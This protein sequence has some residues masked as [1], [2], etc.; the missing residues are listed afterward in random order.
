MENTKYEKRIGVKALWKTI[1][2][3]WRILLVI[4]VPIAMISIITTQLIL[5]KKYS[6]NFTLNNNYVN[7]DN[8]NYEKVVA[9]VKKEETLAQT[10]QNLANRNIDISATQ[11][12]NG[13]S[14]PAMKSSTPYIVVTY[15]STNKSIVQ[16]V[17]DE[18]SLVALEKVK[19][20]FPNMSISSKSNDST[21]TS[22]ETAYMFIALAAGAVLSFAFAFIDEVISDEVYDKSDI[23]FYGV[24]AFEFNVSKKKGKQ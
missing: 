1:I 7:L 23:E 5:P 9:V 10:S 4:F 15:T 20:N 8:S 21:K 22:K 2:R 14:I 6:S 24:P 13:I 17:I 18:L 12:L 11:I 19:L 3:R 16:P